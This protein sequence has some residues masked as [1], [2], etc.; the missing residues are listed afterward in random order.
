MSPSGC[1]KALNELY[2]THQRDFELWDT[3][4]V[5]FTARCV[6]QSIG[7]RVREDGAMVPTTL[8]TS[9]ER[10]R[11]VDCLVWLREAPPRTY[12]PISAESSSC[13]KVLLGAPMA[14]RLMGPESYPEIPDT[15]RS[16]D[17]SV[18]RPYV[19]IS[20]LDSDVCLATVLNFMARVCF[21]FCLLIGGAA[22]YLKL[23]RASLTASI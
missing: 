11:V 1:W 10:T 7:G 2:T 16:A 8:P 23:V 12:L 3:V 21:A 22:I 17:R 5:H 19:L 9:M 20:C 18:S 13:T 6:P 4:K 15:L 14:R